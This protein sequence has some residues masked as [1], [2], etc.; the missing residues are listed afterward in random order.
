MVVS[1]SRGVT[2]TTAGLIIRHYSKYPGIIMNQ[3]HY[4]VHFLFLQVCITKENSWNGG[5]K[6]QFA[7][8]DVTLK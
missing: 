3:Q 5:D 8:Y 6:D 7:F 2:T 1:R 4:T